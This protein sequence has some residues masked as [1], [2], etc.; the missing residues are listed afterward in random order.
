MNVP[1]GPILV[2]E[3]IPNVLELLEVTLRFKGYPVITAHNGQEAL[4]TIARERPAIVITD[5]LMPK[6]DGYAL[7]QKLRI[8][9]QTRNIPIVFLS[10]TYVTPE[11][12]AFALSLGAVRFLEKPVDTEEFLLTIAEVLTQEP[13][14]SPEPLSETDFYKGYRERLET[15]LRHKNTQI[16]RTE[17]LLTTLPAEQKPAF[18]AL[19]TEARRHRDEIQQELN[20]LYRLLE[21]GQKKP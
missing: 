10:A 20:D 13:P 11:D 17:R 6:L 5:I 4:E 12:R 2:V 21:N 8:D 9:Q 15:K 14:T 3:D 16:T 18:E 19:L 7:A 1:S